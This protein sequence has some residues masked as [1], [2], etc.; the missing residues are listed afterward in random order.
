MTAIDQDRRAVRSAYLDG[1]YRPVH[2]EHTVD[3][4]TV[5]A[6]AV[7]ADLEGLFVRNG[8]NP[9]FE[10]RGRYHWFDG[11]GM[12]HGVRFEGGRASYRNRWVRT[13]GLAADLEA[14]EARLGGI[15]ERPDF[16]VPD[17]P[18][19]D[20]G[21]TDL[22][23]HGNKLYALWWLSG[24]AHEIALPSLETVG[25]TDFDG[26]LTTSINAHPKVDPTTGE[27][28]FTSYSMLP[29]YL[30]FGVIDTNGRVVHNAA[31]DLPGPRLQ[32]DLAI[33]PRFSVL[34]D[35]S[36][37]WDP[38][39]LARGR[40]HVRFYRDVPSRIGLAPRFGTGDE[41]Q[42]FEVAPFFMYH[43][44]N[45]WEEGDE[46]VLLGCRMAEPLADD[47]DNVASNDGVPILAQLRLE[48]VLWEW[49]LDRSTGLA[50]E[51][52]IDDTLA[53]FPRINDAWLGRRNRW[54]YS[55]TFAAMP[56]LAFDGL[57]RHDLTDGSTVEYRYP[58]GWLGGEAAFAPSTDPDRSDEADGYLVTLVTEAATGRSEAQVFDAR[59]LPAG[60]VVRLEVPVRIPI[61]YHTEWV[62]ASAWAGTDG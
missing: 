27:M 41:V 14:G 38:D 13:A 12:L 30:T 18:F 44:V 47:P 52:A 50:T 5:V 61:G 56:T 28:I 3:D 1:P 15:L 59:D 42:W 32:H 62:P 4:L 6:G 51:R 11:D 19:K 16:S 35:M 49:R 25:V 34:F 57:V 55:P 17:G 60:P 22:V 24:K 40:T 10:P 48:P 26:T 36:L 31:V 21:N 8:S 23:V 46:V 20:T 37:Q 2:E 54:S 39:Q 33:T 29:P 9:A 45:A 7:P 53:E 58:D 43:V